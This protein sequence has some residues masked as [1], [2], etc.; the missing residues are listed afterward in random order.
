MLTCLEHIKAQVHQNTRLLQA[1]LKKSDE[2]QSVEEGEPNQ[3]NIFPLKIK[4]DVDKLE[5]KLEDVEVT[6]QLV[7]NLCT[8]GGENVKSTV[9]RLLSY[10]FANDLAIRINWKGKGGK[11]AFSSLRIKDIVTRTVRKN[12]LTAAATDSEICTI[13]KDWFRFASDRE[14]GR[15]KREERKRMNEEKRKENEKGESANDSE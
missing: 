11:I 9:R 4:D 12:R 14:G 2:I 7:K 1:I 13:I 5:E 8:I 3:F 15:K 6:N 10:L